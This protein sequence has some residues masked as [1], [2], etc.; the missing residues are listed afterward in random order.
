M[1]ELNDT[2]E[3]VFNDVLFDPEDDIPEPPES[4]LLRDFGDLVPLYG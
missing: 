4:W 2:E 1:Y 3:V